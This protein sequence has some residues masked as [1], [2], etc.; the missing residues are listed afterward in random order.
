MLAHAAGLVA[1]LVG[2][3]GFIVVLVKQVEL[4]D[5]PNPRLTIPLFVATLIPT[6]VAFARKE[7]SYA[8]PLLGLGLAAVAMV[9][10]WFF[11]VIGVAIAAAILI[12]ILSQIS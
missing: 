12:A 3:I 7:K 1:L 4:I 11:V 8:L 10:G 6:A 2:G 9:L 5:Q